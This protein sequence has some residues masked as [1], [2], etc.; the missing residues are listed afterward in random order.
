[1]LYFESMIITDFGPY[2]GEQKIS[3]SDDFGVT[4]FWGNN[5]RG[6]TTL[7]NAFR[8]ALF[9]VIQR[10]NGALKNLSEMINSE[11]KDEGRYGFSIKLT[12]NNDGDKYELSRRIKLRKGVIVPNGEEDYEKEVFL[13]KNGAILSPDDRDHELNLI[14]PEQVSRFFLFDA[15]LLQEYEEL[16]EIDT[17]TGD[18]IK[19]A[20]E[21][22]LGV[23]VLQNGVVDIEDCLVNYDKQRSKAAQ[24]DVKT[25][26]FGNQLEQIEA[27]IKQHESIIFE[28]N[29]ELSEMYRESKILENRMEET[30]KLRDWL[31]QKE[32][33][34]NEIKDR[35]I[36]LQEIEQ[37]IKEVLKD[38]WKGMLS[39]TINNLREDTKDRVDELQKKRDTRM[40]AEH[41]LEEIKIAIQDRECPVCHQ[42]VSGEVL[43]ELKQRINASK[44]EFSGLTEEENE[45]LYKLR[46]NLESLK[47]LSFVS[48]KSE[49]EILENKRNSLQIKIGGLTQTIRELTESINSISN[50]EQK[51]A[52][53]KVARDYA[54]IIT[55]IDLKKQGLSAEQKVLKEL[56]EKKEVIQAT[57]T[58]QAAGTDYKKANKRYEICKNIYDIFDISKTKYRET[59]KQNVQE[60]ATSLF[61]DLTGDKDYIGL[62]INE[63]Y[64]LSIVHKSGRLVPGRSSGY[65]HIVALSL[66]GALHKNAPLQGPIIMDSPFGRLDPTHKANIVRALPYMANQSILLAYYGE[67]DEQ[68]ARKELSYHLKKEYKLERISSMYTKID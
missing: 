59:L 66:I 37:Q 58:K 47:D 57:I 14:M 50:E 12:M 27:N 54:S 24:R 1:M 8:F 25:T 67:I 20:I 30:E 38:A 43:A 35:N 65:E 60:D 41:F 32:A 22:I 56:K 11:A 13:K 29:A 61:K 10:R 42:A 68:T 7:L 2:K 9:G 21:K 46:N 62:K 26:Q 16:L 23:P 44:S 45:L 63:N 64:G 15:E 39:S 31:S 6:K 28:Q 55:K 3:F 33:A 51:V 5:G 17:S 53:S 40:V 34:E 52:A 36:E 48:K 49:M 18:R 4:I 19:K